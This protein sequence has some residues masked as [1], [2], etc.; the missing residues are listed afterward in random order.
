LGTFDQA[1]KDLNGDSVVTSVVFDIPIRS[2]RLP[3]YIYQPPKTAMTVHGWPTLGQM[4]LGGKRVVTLT[5]YSF[6]TANVPYM[7]WEV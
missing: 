1:Q 2:S 3:K 5:D 7:P 6:D 4:I